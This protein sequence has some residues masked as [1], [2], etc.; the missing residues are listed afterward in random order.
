MVEQ[1]SNESTP[2]KNG[3]DVIAPVG[4]FTTNFFAG[5]LPELVVVG[6]AY[7]VRSK[8]ATSTAARLTR[9]KRSRVLSHNLRSACMPAVGKA[10][11]GAKGRQHLCTFVKAA[12][13][14][15]PSIEAPGRLAAGTAESTLRRR[16]RVF[17][18]DSIATGVKPAASAH[19]RFRRKRGK[20]PST[21]W[22]CYGKVTVW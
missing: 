2:Q 3:D 6:D 19:I 9:I 7:L 5:P 10:I 16:N 15:Q 17:G 20:A 12:T 22:N 1:V 14:P 11:M 13:L 8:F 21:W 4:Q 18:R